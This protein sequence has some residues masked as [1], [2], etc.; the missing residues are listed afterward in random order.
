MDIS[1]QQHLQGEILS[2][3]K[4]LANKIL[5]DI[6]QEVANAEMHGL[7]EDYFKDLISQVTG[8]L[9]SDLRSFFADLELVTDPDVI[10]HRTV[11]VKRLL[12]DFEYE[13]AMVINESSGVPIELYNFIEYILL[14]LKQAGLNR[15]EYVLLQGRDLSTTNLSSGLLRLFESFPRTKAI[16]E[17]K[18]PFLHE[19]LL[20]PSLVRST[21]DWVFVVHEI[22]HIIENEFLKIIDSIYPGPAYADFSPEASVVK[23]LYSKEFQADAIATLLIGPVL[24]HRTIKSY[25][26]R[27]IRISPTHPAWSERLAVMQEVLKRLKVEFGALSELISGIPRETPLIQRSSIERLQ[28]ILDATLSHFSEVQYKQTEAELQYCRKRI[29]SMNPYSGKITILLNTAIDSKEKLLGK[30]SK[31]KQ[32]ESLERDFNYLLKDSIRLSY[33]RRIAEPLLLPP[34]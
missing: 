6:E 22:G 23:R 14:D 30:V 25:Y 12:E 29:E 26:T 32:R 1:A 11:L 16:I 5:N 10:F 21:V 33:I 2:E 28:E 18:Y 34:S 27:E 7:S 31:K 24:V 20:P 4:V 8:R 17:S 19:I 9:R 13:V 3:S 15:P